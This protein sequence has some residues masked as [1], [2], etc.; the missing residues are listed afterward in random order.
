[1]QLLIRLMVAVHRSLT[2]TVSV[3]VLAIF[4]A[5]ISI[6][7]AAGEYITH[8]A[9]IAFK[10]DSA[11]VNA[12]YSHDGNN[13]ATDNGDANS[14]GGAA[15]VIAPDSYSYSVV[16]SGCGHSVYGVI[17][18]DGNGGVSGFLYLE[19]GEQTTFYGDWVA[20]GVAE[21]VD[22]DGNLYTVKVDN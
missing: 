6:P 19:N 22:N 9:R 11:A 1:M 14:S 13:C 8:G 4:V 16:G 10:R 7:A 17:N 12:G 3:L 2:P 15:L 20:D 21:G 18:A 5:A